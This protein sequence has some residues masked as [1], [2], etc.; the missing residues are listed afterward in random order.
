MNEGISFSSLNDLH[1]TFQESTSQSQKSVYYPLITFPKP[2]D[3]RESNNGWG[4]TI[5]KLNNI[6]LEDRLQILN[7]FEYFIWKPETNTITRAK[8]DSSYATEKPQKHAIMC[9]KIDNFL[10]EQ[11]LSIYDKDTNTLNISPSTPNMTR[12]LMKLDVYSNFN[13][14]AV[15]KTCHNEYEYFSGCL[16]AT[17][18]DLDFL[19]NQAM[20][21]SRNLTEAIFWGLESKSKSNLF[22]D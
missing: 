17:L 18:E 5:I 3:I 15:N 6:K 19:V 22:E 2:R 11:T 9:K 10:K 8:I 7:N 4:E 21:S 14:T 1:F 20:Q 16:S 13:G 12:L